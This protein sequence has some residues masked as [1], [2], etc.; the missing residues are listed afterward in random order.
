ME[1]HDRRH[2]EGRSRREDFA[3]RP[4]QLDDLDQVIEIE[5]ESFGEPWSRKNFE[6]EMLQ[7]AA[8]ELVVAVAGEV[9]LG[10]T[11]TWFLGEDVHLANVAVRADTREC[12]VGR[13][14]V[15]GVIARARR[16]GARRV[17]LEVR[18][19]NHEARNLYDS[20]GFHQVGIRRNYYKKEREDAILMECLL[21]G[22]D[23][24]GEGPVQ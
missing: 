21:E 4:M 10:Y 9:V 18:E 19:S 22:A 12:G 1:D 14:L 5:R 7:L 15:E 6:Y 23:E 20:L 17:L 16:A 24:G 11:V 8:S 13:A 2:G 3:L